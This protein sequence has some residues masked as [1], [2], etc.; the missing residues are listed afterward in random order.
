MEE[1]ER[2]IEELQKKYGH[3]FF[4]NFQEAMDI[5]EIKR[6]A[7]HDLLAAGQVLAH[8]SDQQAGKKGVR[9]IAASVWSHLRKGVI[10]SEQWSR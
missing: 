8:S 1:L 3:R 7:L 4:F 9:I 10:P 6:D 2:H 5:L